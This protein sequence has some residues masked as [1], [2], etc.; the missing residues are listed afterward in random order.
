MVIRNR[1]F[2]ITVLVII[3]SCTSKKPENDTVDYKSLLM[4]TDRSFSKLSEQKGIKFA[5]IQF[6]ENKGVLLRPERV[7]IV[8]GQAINYI[9]QLNDSSY[10][11]TWEPKGANVALSGEMGYT[12]GVY[13]VK[14]NDKDTVLY[15]TYVSIWK[16][17]TDG[18]WKFVLQSQ[19]EE[20]E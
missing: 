13:S 4:D 15:G 14:P 2:F 8:G 17:Q 7:P 16:Q 3:S 18:K 12:Y 11:M 6:I 10:T 19:N 1:F 9:S 20:I 5:L